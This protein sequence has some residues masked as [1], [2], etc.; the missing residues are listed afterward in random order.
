MTINHLFAGFSQRGGPLVILGVIYT[1]LVIAIA[2]AVFGLL[3][4]LFGAA[5]IGQLWNLQDPISAAT[6]FGGLILAVLVGMLAF[7]LLYL[8]L[9]MAIWFAPALVIFHNV[10]P[11]AAMKQSFAGCLNNTL[12]FLVYGL[13]GIVLAIAASI[14]LM[15]G[16]ILLVPVSL[17][18]IYTSYCDIFE[19]RGVAAPPAPA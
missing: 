8:P 7:L 18:S 13:V 3:F 11:W 9:V 2:A 1:A 6:A 15:L 16:W 12:P 10:E 19:D 14:P 5:V 17:A 4:V